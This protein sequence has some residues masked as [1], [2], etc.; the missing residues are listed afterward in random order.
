MLK[1]LNKLKIVGGITIVTLIRF[2]RDAFFRFPT[3][4][5]TQPSA[6]GQT[7]TGQVSQVPLK[8]EP[9]P[10]V[11]SD[12]FPSSTFTIGNYSPVTF[13]DA[14]GGLGP[15]AL[16][17]KL[18]ERDLKG[19]DC[20]NWLADKTNISN[21]ADLELG[22]GEL[23]NLYGVETLQ[24][25]HL[26]EAF[27]ATELYVWIK[28]A[29]CG[30]LAEEG[31]HIM[32]L[33][34][35]N[36]RLLYRKLQVMFRSCKNRTQ[37][38]DTMKAI[39]PQI[40]PGN[41][42]ASRYYYQRAYNPNYENKDYSIPNGTKRALVIAN[43]DGMHSM[44]IHPPRKFELMSDGSRFFDN[45]P[46]FIRYQL[47]KISQ[48]PAETFLVSMNI[49]SISHERMQGEYFEAL[50]RFHTNETNYTQFC[51][52]EWNVPIATCRNSVMAN[53][54]S[55]FLNKVLED[56]V[57]IDVDVYA[58]TGNQGHLSPL[59]DGRHYSALGNLML[60]QI[61]CVYLLRR[62]ENYLTSI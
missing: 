12:V 31:T 46:D 28:K 19:S 32:F 35:S 62:V 17:A 33:G 26:E 7:K 52:L 25:Y 45:F 3:L 39:E 60:I 47:L 38:T 8:Q 34:D 37:V 22:L 40:P 56:I 51:S 29:I 21:P 59:G 50:Q 11:W 16:L 36:V 44:S 48:L 9:P 20:S 49:N 41:T 53:S 1:N 54:G 30:I 5:I 57:P 27:V 42:A 15:D 13:Y 55:K 23:A 58:I 18:K 6:E 2:S 24:L 14:F 4:G 61:A 10:P 43:F